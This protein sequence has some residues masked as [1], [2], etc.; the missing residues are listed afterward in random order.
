MKSPWQVIVLYGTALVLSG[1]E[2]RK[3]LEPIGGSKAD[4]TVRLGY[5]FDRFEKPIV[6]WTQGQEIAAERCRKWGYSGAEEFSGA[7]THCDQRNGFGNCLSGTV[8][9]NYQCTGDLASGQQ[10]QQ[11]DGRMEIHMR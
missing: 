7:L 10:Q 1:C 11:Q 8:V 9:K 5:Q 4:G 6:D 2:T 3:E